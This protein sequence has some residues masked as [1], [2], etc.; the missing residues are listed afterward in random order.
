M[1]DKL[2]NP[3]YYFATA[4]ISGCVLIMFVIFPGINDNKPSMFADSIYGKADKPYV[5]R[6]L[7]PTTVRILSTTIPESVRNSLSEKIESDVS[8]NK[9]FKK[10]KWEKEFVVE[11]SFAMILMFLSLWGFS[12]AVRY[13]FYLF[14]SSPGWFAD[15]VSILALLGLPTMFQYTSFLYDFPLLFLF[16]LGLIFLYKQDWKTFLIIFVIGCFNKETTILLTMVFYFYYKTKLNKDLIKKLLIA[17][18]AAFSLIKIFLFIIFKD[19][20]GTFVEFHLVDHNL[21]LLTGYDL[22]LA[23]SLL[24]FLLTGYDLTLAASLL[25]FVLLVFYKWKEKPDFIKTS[26]LAFIPLVFLSLFLG[27]IDELRD[28]YEVYPS[29]IILIS[30][31]IGR[32]LKV[33]IDILPGKDF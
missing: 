6:T 30:Y 32:I 29:V 25:G 15:S 4:L 19:N 16:T 1:N 14:F 21:R 5:Y 33:K 8:L 12:I 9:L 20:P 11:Y 18:V 31:S 27:Y 13:L 23:A 2:R 17:Q 7:L 3:I 10:L 28:Y 26:L 22:T 24:G